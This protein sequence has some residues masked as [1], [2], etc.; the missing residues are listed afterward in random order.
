MWIWVLV[1]CIVLT[2]G[3]LMPDMGP[4]TCGRKC[5][6]SY[7]SDVDNCR[8]QYD[9]DQADAEALA[10]CIREAQDEYRNCL[11]DCANPSFSP[12]SRWRLAGNTL[13]LPCRAPQ[14]V[15]KSHERQNPLEPRSRLVRSA[16]RFGAG[17]W[18]QH[19]KGLARSPLL[20]SVRGPRD[21]G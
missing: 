6:V 13:I 16:I 9:N 19:Q 10:D 14:T 17:D 8:L 4:A 1:G 7:S 18:D 12:P 21:K 2:L 15:P 20:L 11:G 3:M 5:D